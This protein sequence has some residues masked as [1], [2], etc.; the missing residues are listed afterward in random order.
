[1]VEVTEG[2]HRDDRA[3]LRKFG[4]IVQFR[5]APLHGHGGDQASHTG[6]GE[7]EHGQFPAIGKLDHDHVILTQALRQKRLSGRVDGPAQFRIG[8]PLRFLTQEGFP[9]EGVDQT[10]L[11]RLL[12]DMEMEIIDQGLLSPGSGCRPFLNIFL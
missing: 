6:D 4:D 5:E 8:K 1:M 9:V 12:S 7:V 10:N 11:F 3:G 2:L